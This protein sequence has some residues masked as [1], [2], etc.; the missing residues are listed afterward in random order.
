MVKKTIRILILAAAVVFFVVLANSW[1]CLV[2][3]FKP[4][5]ACCSSFPDI[6]EAVALYGAS[7]CGTCPVGR[8]LQQVRERE[9]ILYIVPADYTANDVANLRSGFAL[10]GAVIRGGADVWELM[11]ALGKCVQREN[12]DGFNFVIMITSGKI[13]EFRPL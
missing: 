10:R 7:V 6:R 12:D 11:Q 1:H 4:L 8:Y 5:P 3:S 9:D 2:L 13:R